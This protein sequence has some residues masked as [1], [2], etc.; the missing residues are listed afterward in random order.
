LWTIWRLCA[1]AK[2]E[3]T[4]RGKPLAYVSTGGR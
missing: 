3:I 1:R 4:R 2:E